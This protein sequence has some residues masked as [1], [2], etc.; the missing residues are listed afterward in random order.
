MA[1][2]EVAEG[3]DDPQHPFLALLR[4]EL[5]LLLVDD[6]VSLLY[7]ALARRL[8]GEG[9]LIGSNDLW[10]GATSLRHQLPLVTADPSHL[11]RVEGLEVVEYR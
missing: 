1:L 9:R 3:F 2:G 4:R 6:E 5:V 11:G 10:I 8:R 7:G